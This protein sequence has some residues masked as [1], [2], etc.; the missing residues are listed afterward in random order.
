MSEQYDHASIAFNA[1]RNCSASAVL[2][3]KNSWISSCLYS[4]CLCPALGLAQLN[5]HLDTPVL[6]K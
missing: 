3:V 6:A 2:C 4:L 5:I 1:D